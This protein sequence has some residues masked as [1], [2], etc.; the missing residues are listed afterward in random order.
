MAITG[1]AQAK[2]RIDEIVNDVVMDNFEKQ[3]ALRRIKKYLNTNLD[4]L[5]AL[6]LANPPSATNV[7]KVYELCKDGKVF[8]VSED[9]V[10]KPL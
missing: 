1:V 9:G 4:A 2:N 7:P 8:A 5:L 3:E 10:I 6:I